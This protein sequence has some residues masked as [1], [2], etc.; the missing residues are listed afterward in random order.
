MRVLVIGAGAVG[1]WMAGTL[2]RGGAEVAVLARGATLEAIRAD[3]L[4]LIEAERRQSFPTPRFRSRRGSAEARR[5]RPGGQDLRL[6]RSRR[7]GPAGV[8]ATDRWW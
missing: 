3:G 4:T 5:N 1:G 8:R 2:A 6:C 7:L